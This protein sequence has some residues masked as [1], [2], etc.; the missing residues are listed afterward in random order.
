[1]QVGEQVLQNGGSWT[2]AGQ[3]MGNLFEVEMKNVIH[4]CGD[5]KKQ[6][7]TIEHAQVHAKVLQNLEDLPL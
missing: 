4:Q 1:M 2:L 6:T 5:Q 7:S 3:S